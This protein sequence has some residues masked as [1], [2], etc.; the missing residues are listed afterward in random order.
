MIYDV[1]VIGGGPAGLTSCI[2]TCRAG[3]KTICF[4]KLATGGQANLSLEV[5]NYPGFNSI[6]G[7]ELMEKFKDHALSLGAKISFEEVKSLLKEKNKFILK[8]A[9][10]QY[11]AKKVI[12]AC[13]CKPRMLGLKEEQSF[14]G[15]GVSYCANCD[16]PFFKNKT[17]AIVGGGDTAFDDAKYLAQL[18][19]KVYVIVR[20]EKLRV[21]SK[22]KKEVLKNKNIEILYS[23]VVEKLYGKNS[24]TKI[25]IKNNISGDKQ[26]LKIDG[27]FVAIGAVP[28]LA[29]LK[30]DIEKDESG[31]IVVD[32]N[33]ATSDKNLFACG[34]ITN[35]KV[36]QIVCAC[37][38]GA[39]AGT[40][41]IEGGI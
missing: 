33:Q 31:Y 2:Y 35:G 28:D 30:F 11:V 18:C 24:L 15:K 1:A 32:K 36:K 6:N 29:F 40:A 20:S 3:L 10:N 41:C 9:N 5:T 4:E 37:G 27:L 16:G 21:S 7:F 13:G 19:E 25:K 17:V 14:I 38:D 26:D 39:K 23:T 34:D 22:K 8:T 12:I